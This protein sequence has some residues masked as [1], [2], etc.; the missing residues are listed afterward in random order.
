MNWEDYEE[1]ARVNFSPIRQEIVTGCKECGV[2][3]VGSDE[4]I[5]KKRRKQHAILHVR[6]QL[7]IKNL[8]D[9]IGQDSSAPC[10]K[11]KEHLDK[12]TDLLARELHRE[13]TNHLRFILDSNQIWPRLRVP[14]KNNLDWVLRKKWDSLDNIDKERFLKI[15][16]EFVESA[17]P[18]A[19]A[20]KEETVATAEADEHLGRAA[21]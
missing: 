9:G 8:I 15:A 13:F 1:A 2:R 14:Q 16:T 21:R 4:K 10:G 19:S 18:E 3:I 5:L 20:G 11:L 6:S 17:F 7:Y 12:M